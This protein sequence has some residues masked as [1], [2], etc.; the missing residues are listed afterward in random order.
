MEIVFTLASGRSG[1]SFLTGLFAANI[2]NCVALHE[3]L[4][5]LNDLAIGWYD[6]GEAE[7]I[8]ELFQQTRHRID[9]LAESGVTVYLESSHLFLKSYCDI[10]IKYYPTMK[11]I[12]LIRNPLEVAK[13]MFNRIDPCGSLSVENPYTINPTL[14]IFQELGEL[15]DYQKFLV[16]WIEI[17]NRA[18]QFSKRHNKNYCVVETAQLNDPDVIRRM[19]CE[20]GISCA[21]PVITGHKNANA[22]K[23]TYGV[24]EI[25]EF[26]AVIKRMKPEHLK[27]VSII[28]KRLEPDVPRWLD[29]LEC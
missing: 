1:T 6:N 13:S 7:K 3:P 28:R 18:I 27:M 24:R 16:Q 22:N 9:I 23:T 19:F 20:L 29:V 17:Q 5:Y 15:T 4:P 2:K 14:P 10:A 25:D 26:K 8:D 11:L 21:Q 12:W